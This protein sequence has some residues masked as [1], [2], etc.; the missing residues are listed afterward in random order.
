[1]KNV[2]ELLETMGKNVSMLD[3]IALEQAI[4]EA[5]LTAELVAAVQAGDVE[6][7]EMLLGKNGDIFCSIKE[8]DEPAQEDEPSE[9]EP[10]KEASALNY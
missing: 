4:A 6:Q 9:E 8:A 3:S 2:I 1:M 5:G 7:V 10:K